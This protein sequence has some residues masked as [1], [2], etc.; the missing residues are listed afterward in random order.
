MN[1]ETHEINA[2]VVNVKN[3]P[4]TPLGVEALEPLGELVQHE[5]QVVQTYTP[6]RTRPA[7][8]LSGPSPKLSATIEVAPPAADPKTRF[9]RWRGARARAAALLSWGPRKLTAIIGVGLLAA[10]HTVAR[11]GRWLG[12]IHTR[13]A[14]LLAWRPRKVGAIIGV[15]SLAA[16]PVTRLGRWLGVHTRIASLLSWRP[17]KVGAIIGLAPLAVRPVTR[18][19]RWLGRWIASLL[20]W[21]PRKLGA[22]IGLAPLAVRPMT[23]LGRWL[24][25]W[26]ASLLSWPPRKLRAIIGLAPLAVRPVIRLGRWLGVQQVGLA[27]TV[28]GVGL[29][30]A[31]HWQ[32]AWG[33]Y[34]A[35]CVAMF[36][37]GW[38]L[39][40]GR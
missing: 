18:L 12:G 39:G 20:S 17:R 23:R 15:A 22:I 4:P 30:V 35:A 16:R 34:A 2:L 36:A 37:L 10:K 32:L 7:G 21:P 13:I 33:G 38:H 40:F 28:E 14:S 25:R 27:I 29:S 8:L 6:L 3:E 19:G 24:G 11:L 1:Q 9:R 5:V 26:I 31:R